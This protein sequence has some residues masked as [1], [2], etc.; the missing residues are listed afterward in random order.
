MFRFESPIYLY[1]L[2]LLPVTVLLHYAWNY[3]RRSR[4]R[5]YGDKELVRLLMT[6]VSRLRQEIKFWLFIG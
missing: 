3:I 4:L 1:L 6:D 2:L 5:K